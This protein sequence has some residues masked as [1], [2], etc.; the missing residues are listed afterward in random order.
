MT[1]RPTS[2]AELQDAVRSQNALR[3]RGRGTKSPPVGS[4]TEV[5]AGTEVALLDTTALAGI[6]E[7]SPDECVFTA[8]AGTPVHDIDAVLA[9]HRQY[10]PFDPPFARQGA[11]IGGTVAAGVSGAERYRY[12]G[13]R[14]F[15]IGARVVDGEGRLL[16]SG[17]KVVKNA[18][19]F[20][21]HHGMVGSRGRFGV[22]AEVTFKVFPAPDA[23]LT[24]RANC[25]SLSYAIDT[26]HAVELARLDLAAV[27]FDET[28]MLWIR[29]AGRSDGLSARMERLRQVVPWPSE[30]LSGT[31][32]EECWAIAREFTWA[33]PEDALIKIPVAAPLPA[34]LGFTHATRYTCG[35][36]CLWAAVADADAFSGRLAA[37]G[38]RG[39]VVRGPTAGAIVGAAMHN[40][41]EQRVRTVL[42]PGRRFS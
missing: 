6:S 23:R 1:L 14:D 39:Q 29:L 3:I 20:L 8:L 22:L 10:L 30:V 36:K 32:D 37:A 4:R 27:D 41:F 11:T 5:A 35:G 28:G 33:D 17:G 2:I 7:Y 40:V 19:G 26:L 24:L 9:P 38:L 18:A 42:D 13:V 25:G 21:L 15:I 31:D 16:H 12:G 34:G